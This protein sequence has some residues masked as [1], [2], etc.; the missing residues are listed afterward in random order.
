MKQ[1]VR[2]GI[3]CAALMA[4]VSAF[5]YSNPIDGGTTEIVTNAYQVQVPW[6]IVGGND[7]DNSLIIAD[8][9]QVDNLVGY[10]G[11][12][13]SSSNNSAL[14]TGAGAAWYS[15]MELSVGYVGA[16]NTL[17]IADGGTVATPNA[18]IGNISDGN[19]TIV[20]GMNSL[21]DASTLNVGYQ[22][23]GNRLLVTDGG[24]AESEVGTIGYW[25]GSDNNMATVQ[26][27]GSWNNSTELNVGEYGAG[28]Q[29]VIGAGGF[30]ESPGINVGAQTISSN[31]TVTVT[32]EGAWLDTSQL[33]VGG[34][35]SGAG[36]TGNLVEVEGGGTVY[37]ESFSIYAGSSFDLNDSGRLFINTNFNASMDNFNWN[38]GGTLEVGGELTGMSTSI[39]D[40]RSLGLNGSNAVWDISL[41]D[42]KVGAFTDGNTLSIVNGGRV[43]GESFYIGYSS[44]A[45][46]NSVRVA[47]AGSVLTN[48]A[49][50]HVGFDGSNNSMLIENGGT[51]RSDAGYIGYGEAAGGNA[52]TVTGA[53]SLWDSTELYLIIS[54]QTIYIRYAPLGLSVG[55]QGSGNQLTISEGGQVDST[56]GYIGYDA[57]ASGNLATVT[58][59]GSVWA[60][61]GQLYVGYNGSGNT[62]RIEDGSYVHAQWG[63]SIGY[64]E[65]ANGNHVVVSG[66]D[67]VWSS[68]WGVAR[69]IEIQPPTVVS[70]PIDWPPILA[71]FPTNFPPIEI[72]PGITNRPPAL[73][74]YPVNPPPYVV[75]SGNSGSGSVLTVGGELMLG[76]TL[77][78][79]LLIITNG[80]SVLG[81]EGTLLPFNNQLTV[82]S[83]SFVGG[84]GDSVLISASMASADFTPDSSIIGPDFTNGIVQESVFIDGPIIVISNETSIV[85]NYFPPQPVIAMRMYA[86]MGDLAVGRGGSDNL[87][88]ISDGALVANY[89]GIIGEMSYA[90]NNAVSVVGTN[91]EWR[92]MGDLYIGGRM[93]Q[94]SYLIDDEWFTPWVDGGRGNSLY[95]G[96]GGRV[97]VEGELHNRNYSMLNLD[98]GGLLTIGGDYYQ[99]DTAMLRFG[100]ETNVAGAP[101]NALITVGGTAEF[102][103][104]AQIE[105]A[106]NVG[107]LQFDRFYTNQLIEADLLI[108]AG[109]TNA[110]SLD[111]ELLD[112][113]GSLVDVIFWEYDQDIYALAGRKHLADSAGF[114]EGSMMARLSKEIDDMSLLGN[115]DA[116]SMINLLNTLSESEQNE[117]LVQQYAYSTPGYL[118]IQGMTEGL[119]ELAKHV[120][121]RP[122]TMP[123]GATGPY[124][125]DRE[126]RGWIKPYGSWSHRS[127]Q[128]GFAGY[129]HN[130]YGTIVGMD[131]VQSGILVGVAGGYARSNIKQNDG[132]TSKANTGYGAFYASAGT[133]DWFGDVSLAVGRSNIEDDSGTAF[134]AHADY[135]ASNF[136]LYLG[137]GKEMRSRSG[138]LSLTPAASLLL[139]DYYQDAYTEEMAPGVARDVA[140]YENSSVL[141]SLGATLAV[142]KEYDIM[143]LKPEARFRWL[144]EFSSDAEQINFSLSEGMGGQYYSQMPAA[145]ED[146]LEVGT[147]LSCTFRDEL[148]L[149]LDLDWRFGEDYDAYSVSGRA[150]FEF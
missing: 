7:A 44:G 68:G 115:S 53:G 147:G 33:Y 43:E 83:G 130:I 62:L 42:I 90:W 146:I 145:E 10:I 97:S 86:S 104:G 128:D 66:E 77:S 109:V 75:Y 31:N 122:M 140:S 150:V 58:G 89:H 137:G 24:M 99:D 142:Q 119:D 135:K 74:N 29:L 15:S 81:G 57:A 28:N 95:V 30:V 76:N 88:E 132:D 79:N 2:L 60:N 36:G 3:Q 124:S 136:A 4:C 48:S 38:A 127:A 144:H 98:P 19:Q 73:T 71:P 6:Y 16:S 20:S 1:S 85:T 107:E 105:Y 12:T 64:G 116:M 84:N 125:A 34:S 39:E 41:S 80:V 91:S 49:S 26:S 93:S 11:H 114:A 117:E 138:L 22:G 113:S 51:V 139:S 141:S 65:S 40:Q 25:I 14:V 100:V 55:Y 72:W 129:D 61:T 101:V 118:H 8:G 126:A 143:V 106:S 45:N 63:S 131:W 148:S 110:N 94:V 121:R 70:P 67:S 9:G 27:N 92:N 35:A 108:V 13:A 102:E 103:E 134:G 52:V 54:N 133:K 47:G 17:T 5:G 69:L 23:D 37:T 120:S 82:S 149:V 18:Y 50:L 123:E 56:V 87:M 59:R 112:A 111:L 96:D 46:N 32:G 78:N 21:L